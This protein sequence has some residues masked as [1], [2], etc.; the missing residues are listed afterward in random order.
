MKRF[1][2]RA[3]YATLFTGGLVLLG[4]GAANASETTGEDGILSGTQ[5]GVSIEL[6]VTISG[7]AVSVIGDSES[8]DATTEVSTGDAGTAWSEPV[9]VT[10]GDGGIGSGSQAV[11]DVSAPVTVSGNAVSVVGDSSSSEATTVVESGDDQSGTDAT[12]SGEDSILGGTQGIVDVVAPVTVGGN[13]VSVIGDA[14]S[15]DAT[16]VVNAGSGSGGDARTSGEDS[17][18]GG[19]QILPDLSLPVTVGGNAVSVIGDAESSDATTVVNAGSGSGGD[20][21]TS[22][23]DSILGGTQILPDLSLPVTVGGNAVSVVGDSTTGG[24][25]TVVTP[26]DPTQPTQPTEP[27]DPTNPVD[28]TDPTNPTNPTDPTT[29]GDGAD[30]GSHSGGSVAASGSSA[31][32]PTGALA[33]T[34]LDA[35]FWER[36]ALFLALTG[37]LLLGVRRFALRR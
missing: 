16:T 17:I 18:L 10:S 21:R 37:A 12:T 8:S 13:A 25:T 31:G 3:L 27:T 23:E 30:S 11:V 20:A 14:E 15:S 9:A 6:P 35:G 22:G 33:A 5:L 4:A 36:L 26:T 28:P 7:N 24:S 1:V 32:V 19:T 29:P 2:S 34:G